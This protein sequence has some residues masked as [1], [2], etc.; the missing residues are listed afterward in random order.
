MRRRPPSPSQPWRTFL[1]NHADQIMAADFFVVPT[2]TFRRLFVLVVLAHDR[3]RIVHIAVTARST[4]AWTSQQ[5]R[6]A[7][8]DDQAPRYLVHNRDRAFAAVARHDRPYEHRR[9]PLWFS[10]T[11]FGGSPAT[12]KCDSVDGLRY[13]AF[14]NA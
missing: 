7:F 6:N 2:V 5:L 13:C 14:G 10:K 9:G 11:Q 3:R 1:A 12:C 8:P 4:A